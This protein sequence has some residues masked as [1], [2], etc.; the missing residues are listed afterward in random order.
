MI[1]RDLSHDR[2]DE[3]GNILIIILLAIALIAALTAA[4]Q[5]SGGQNGNI[6]KETLLLRVSE[7]QRYGSELERGVHYIMQNNLSEVDLRFAH[8]DA[9]SDYGDL[10][11][12]SDKSDQLFAREG[13]AARYRPAPAGINDGSA[14][15]FYGNTALPDV[16]SDEAELVAVLPNVSA[17][18]CTAMNRS[19]GFDGQPE[20]SSTCINSGASARFDDTTQF[21]SSPNTT[22]ETTFSIKPAVQG[23]VRCTGSDT[24][25]YY[26]VLMAR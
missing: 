9:D 7:V 1:R 24:L 19:I 10:D 8:P 2:F 14:W 3:N 17:E 21:D 6:D 15:E 12:D 16:G 4:L 25:H 20:D 23:C 22:E 5:G 11:S 13:G 26:F 18:F